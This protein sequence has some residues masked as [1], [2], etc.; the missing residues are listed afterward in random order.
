MKKF[1]LLLLGL[2][3]IAGGAAAETTTVIFS[4]LGYSNKGSVTSVSVDDN[5]TLTFAIGEGST[6]PTYYDNGT[7]VRL[8]KNNTLT[9]SMATDCTATKMV[10]TCTAANYNKIT[11]DV[12]TATAS[13]ATTTWSGSESTVVFTAS[14]NS[15]IQ[16]IEFTYD[17]PEGSVS[18]PTFSPAAGTYYEAQSVTLSCSTEGASISYSTDEGSNWTTYSDAISITET[19]TLQAKATLNGV[20]SAVATAT[21]T[22]LSPETVSSIRGMYEKITKPASGESS[23]QFIVGFDATVTASRSGNNYVYDGESY[24]MIYQSGTTIDE[25]NVIA[26]GWAATITNYGGL[27]EICP[28]S[29]VTLSS[30]EGGT[31]P[32]PVAITAADVTAD[33]QSEY[34]KLSNVV[35]ATTPTSASF[36][37]TVDGTSIAFYNKFNLSYPKAWTYNITGIVSV[38]SNTPQFLPTAYEPI[39]TDLTT[40][41]FYWQYN[42]AAATE[43]TYNYDESNALVSPTLVYP[44]DLTTSAISYSYADEK[45]IISAIDSSTGALTLTGEAG[46]ATVT[47][48]FAG[49]DYYNAFTASYT[50]TV[51]AAVGS[52][53]AMVAPDGSEEYQQLDATEAASYKF[54]EGAAYNVY[55]YAA[56][57]TSISYD[58]GTGSYTTCSGQDSSN[59]EIELTATT[60]VTAYVNDKSSETTVFTFTFVD[61]TPEGIIVADGGEVAFE[62]ENVDKIEY[63]V[64]YTDGSVVT[65]VIDAASGSIALSG[66]CIVT[67]TFSSSLTSKSCSVTTPISIDTTSDGW[68]I[69][70]AADEID[71]ESQYV[72]GVA[73]SSLLMNATISN[74][75]FGTVAGTYADDRSTVS[76]SD[77]PSYIQFEASDNTSYPYY[78]KNQTGYIAAKDS[79]TDLKNTSTTEAS[80]WNVTINSDNTA[81]MVYNLSSTR[82]ILYNTSSSKFGNYVSKQRTSSSYECTVLYKHVNNYTFKEA[83]AAPQ[84]TDGESLT[85]GTQMVFS[86]MS[87]CYMKYRLS[88]ASASSEA[89]SRATAQSNMDYGTWYS[90]ENDSDPTTLTYT[91]PTMA[92]SDPECTFE[93]MAV[94]GDY[95]SDAVSYTL[96]YDTTTGVSTIVAADDDDAVFYNLQG[97]RVD[98]P[99]NGVFIRRSGNTVTTVFVK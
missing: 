54:L 21:Y 38:N 75:K 44:S 12:G 64:T 53:H 80:A 32:N 90:T 35:I 84:R 23:T 20:E 97:I 17:L 45:G 51:T 85:A 6:A 52:L 43:V 58:A 49:D 25:G 14:A 27:Y 22:I 96:S 71:T 50:L 98:N 61:S 70:T 1:L 62:G 9:V 87:G 15:R 39:A 68:Q 5:I 4:E 56:N 19:T 37:G 72:V 89:P 65:G 92:E 16:K 18:A 86:T 69:V 11:A 28:A 48:S 30:S 88:Q 2:L 40:S 10:I 81:A 99:H 8:Y 66:S 47:A 60:T 42:N 41:D 24:A 76:F 46:T 3:G 94:C 13:G 31:I 73:S 55:F 33:N 82:E 34:A 7:A 78:I 77:E 26:S 93:V 36:T 29:G 63:T 67:A 74:S 79:D 95:E 59:S 83:L 91:I 57:A